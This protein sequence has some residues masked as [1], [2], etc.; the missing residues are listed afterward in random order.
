MSSSSPETL[1]SV[2]KQLVLPLPDVQRQ[3]LATQVAA[4]V[5]PSSASP[6]LPA[7]T[8]TLHHPSHI[9]PTTP[10]HH[11]PFHPSNTPPRPPNGNYV[12]FSPFQRVH[13]PPATSPVARMSSHV[14]PDLSAL[15]SRLTGPP[16]FVSSIPHPST[17]G[18]TA[19]D[20]SHQNSTYPFYLVAGGPWRGIVDS[21]AEAWAASISFK[22]VGNPASFPSWEAAE[23][24]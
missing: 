20:R 2:F 6:A 15:G 18:I 1:A 11:S 9:T 16:L 7:R 17:R 8:S 13:S 4:L 23:D 14:F 3:A 12:N 5:N 10:H 22:G 21:F 19:Q 24:F